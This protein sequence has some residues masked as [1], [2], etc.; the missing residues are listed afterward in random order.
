M[1][2]ALGCRGKAAPT[3]SASASIASS[4]ASQL[5]APPAPPACENLWNDYH[6]LVPDTPYVDHDAFVDR[7][8]RSEPAVLGCIERTKAETMTMF[9]TEVEPD[10]GPADVPTRFLAFA[11]ATR[12]GV[13]FTEERLKFALRTG[14]LDRLAHEIASDPA[15]DGPY[16]IRVVTGTYATLP[17]RGIHE[18]KGGAD[19]A[20]PGEIRVAHRSGGRI[21]L[22]FL[23]A[24]LGRHQNQIGFLY[25]NAPFVPADFT[26]EKTYRGEQQTEVCL[27]SHIPKNTKLYMLDCFTVQE[28][29]TPQ[30]IEVG[31]SPA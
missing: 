8:K 9:T 27:D 26:S 17:W 16:G 1:V 2:L 4:S 23:G 20:P 14:E 10:A 6:A 30:L 19:T 12:G 24:L 7:C 15:A 11:E 22:Y 29:L 18:E 31:A 3:A 28:R 21:W 25:S 13:C 5:D